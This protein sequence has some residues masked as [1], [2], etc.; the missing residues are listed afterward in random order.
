[1]IRLLIGALA[2]LVVA[3]AGWTVSQVTE[4]TSRLTHLE[5]KFAE[6]STLL[7]EIKSQSSLSNE[8][9]IRRLERIEDR[10]E[11]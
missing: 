10:L 4:N 3:Y 8:Q 1:M 5:Q 6:V 9:V 7:R 11:R 2:T